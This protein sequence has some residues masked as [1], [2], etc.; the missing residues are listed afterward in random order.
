MEAAY[1]MRETPEDMQ[2]TWSS[3]G[4]TFDGDLGVSIS[5]PGGAV[6]QVPTW[7][8]KV[9]LVLK[10]TFHTFS[11]QDGEGRREKWGKEKGVLGEV[12]RGVEEAERG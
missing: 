10:N 12:R 4:P 3:R 6:T 5:A 1:S 2:Y 11:A 7:T 8:L 9:S